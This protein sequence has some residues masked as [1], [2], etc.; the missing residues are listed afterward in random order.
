MN[1]I[2]SFFGSILMAVQTYGR[3]LAWNSLTG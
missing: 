1:P 2:W 3:P